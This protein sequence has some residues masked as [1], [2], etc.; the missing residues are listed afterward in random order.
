LINEKIA[1]IAA[2]RKLLQVIY[3]ML[4]HKEPFRIEW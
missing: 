1:I 2:A 4:K 3:H